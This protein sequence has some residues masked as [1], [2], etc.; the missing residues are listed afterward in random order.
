MIPAEMKR[1][2]GVEKWIVALG[3]VFVMFGV[4]AV[5]FPAETYVAHP[6]PYKNVSLLGGP[7]KDELVSKRGSQVYG[8]AAV[9]LGLSMTILAFYGGHRK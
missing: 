3:L 9:V 7:N 5:I 4:Y 6:G 8:G 1:L 2:T